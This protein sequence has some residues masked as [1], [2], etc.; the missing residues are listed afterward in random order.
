MP[1]GP[2]P[3]QEIR[4]RL[5]A[6]PAAR[7]AEVAA[8]FGRAVFDD[9]LRVLRTDDD[10]TLRRVPI[11]PLLTPV[12]PDPDAA[13][14]AKALLDAVIATARAEFTRPAAKS[15]LQD[16]SLFAGLT[17]LE[18]ECIERGWRDAERVAS[19]RVDFLRGDDGSLNVLE[20]NATIPAMQG[21]SDIVAR[22]FVRH[23][24]P[25]L[26]ATPAAV[27]RALA[28][29]PSN[30]DDLRL[31]LLAQAKETG[32]GAPGR[33]AILAR[34]ND[35][36]EGELDW[37]AARWREAGLEAVRVTPENFFEKG[38][39]DLV[40]R[41]LF[42]RR[43]APGHPME[44]VYREPRRFGMWNPVNAHLE[45]KGMIAIISEA[46]HGP[47]ERH[48]HLSP[49][50]ID[51]ARRFLPW[52]RLLTSTKTTL[53]DGSASGDLPAWVAA[54]PEALILK[55][56]WDYGGRS[57][58]LSEDFETPEELARLKAVTGADI[59]SWRDL[60]RF[61]ERDPQGLW[62]AQTRIRPKRERHLRVVDGKPIWADLVTDVSAFSGAGASFHPAGLTARAA[63]GAVV[64][65]VS[66]GGMAPILPAP[67]LA[68]LLAPPA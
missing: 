61:A 7:L 58:F 14:A 62:I 32:A 1:T 56:S 50:S 63:G 48:A 26:G 36:Q 19:A 11:P 13:P 10:G 22:G 59:H 8:S 2:E 4:R 41:H 9:G 25:A 28:A 55:R 30:V 54:H 39:F 27:E 44:Q 46:V 47:A 24:G 42:A 64:N 34:E 66:G 53:P 31:S 38:P 43:L 67:T 45:I 35:S 3:L 65:I 18:K 5:E 20:V 33:W 68:L 6:L 16:S 52:T 23:V 17:A 21:Y 29:L 12:L 15:P 57:V 37:I 49:A 51:A 60:V 40:Y